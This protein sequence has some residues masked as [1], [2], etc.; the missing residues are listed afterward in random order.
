MNSFEK[1]NLLA[2]AEEYLPATIHM[3]AAGRVGQ[4]SMESSDVKKKLGLRGWE[5]AEEMAKSNKN[6][7]ATTS[8]LLKALYGYQKTSKDGVTYVQLLEDIR[9][10]LKD[11]GYEHVPQLCSSRPIENY[12]KFIKI[13]VNQNSTNQ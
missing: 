6:G 8:S 3:F 2:K 5:R 13:N 7:G 12:E 1:R 11:A 9:K 10:R 4:K